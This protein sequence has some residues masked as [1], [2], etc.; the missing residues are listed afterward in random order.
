MLGFQVLHLSGLGLLMEFRLFLDHVRL[1]LFLLTDPHLI[2]EHHFK[3]LFQLR[4][5]AFIITFHKVRCLSQSAILLH[6]PVPVGSGGF[7]LSL[8]SA[9][10][11][12]AALLGLSE[13]ADQLGE[14]VR[15]LHSELKETFQGR[16]VFF[17]LFLLGSE[18]L[19]NTFLAVELLLLSCL[20][21]V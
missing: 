12:F 7:E 5:L 6:E 4:D 15:L 10:L 14:L 8:L 17:Y 20:F 19:Q 21:F 1:I 9:V 11:V 16:L 2:A 13:L 3:V 18:C